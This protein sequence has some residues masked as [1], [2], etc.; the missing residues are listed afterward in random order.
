[1]DTPPWKCI[2]K[3]KAVMQVTQRRSSTHNESRQPGAAVSVALSKT[4]EGVVVAHE[5][6][7]VPVA[8]FHESKSCNNN[9]NVQSIFWKC[10]S[11]GGLIYVYGGV[12]VQYR[13]LIHVCTCTC[14]QGFFFVYQWS[15]L[16]PKFGKYD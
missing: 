16:R 3:N 11:S 4:T 12:Y 8:G 2:R 6:Q 14:T 5:R 13:L 15:Y 10:N 1:M 9:N 7:L